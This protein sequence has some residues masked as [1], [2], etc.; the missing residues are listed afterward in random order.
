[1]LRAVERPSIAILAYET[2]GGVAGYHPG[3][4]AV[5]GD[6]WLRGERSGLPLFAPVTA[7]AIEPLGV[8]GSSFLY[9]SKGSLGLAY[10]GT[11]VG[12]FASVGLFYN[13]GVTG[14]Y[15][16]NYQRELVIAL[17]TSLLSALGYNLPNWFGG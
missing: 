17:F 2:L 7:L 3:F 11:V 14:S 13:Y 15:A 10:V 9:D 1:M 8:F 12:F 6:Q 5:G 4:F 16:S